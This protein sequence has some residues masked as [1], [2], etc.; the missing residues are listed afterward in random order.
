MLHEISGRIQQDCPWIWLPNKLNVLAHHPDV[1]VG[2]FDPLWEFDFR[3]V[4]K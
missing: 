4:W 1:G 3:Q 2:T